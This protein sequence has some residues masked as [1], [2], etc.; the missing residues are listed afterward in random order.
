MQEFAQ[1]QLSVTRGHRTLCLSPSWSLLG[2]YVTIDGKK[3]F[4]LFDSHSYA[5]VW[6]IL[7][8][9]SFQVR[10]H[11]VKGQYIWDTSHIDKQL[12]I[13]S[14]PRL[15]GGH[16]SLAF[17]SKMK[18]AVNIFSNHVGAAL[19]PLTMFNRL[20]PDA[21]HTVPFAELV[22]CLFGFLWEDKICPCMPW[23]S[24]HVFQH[25][26]LEFKIFQFGAAG[27]SCYTPVDF[28]SQ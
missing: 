5:N 21:I 10:S 22:D 17:A 14:V 13:S 12:E 11:V 9:Y 16:F 4:C 20:P 7:L 26:L 2:A 3:L 8:M 28:A 15:A 24:V 6:Y 18:W 1:R 19:F 23:G 27:G 25:C